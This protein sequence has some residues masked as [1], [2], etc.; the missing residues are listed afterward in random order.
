MRRSLVCVGF[1][2]AVAV[3]VQA[4][5]QR[6]VEIGITAAVLHEAVGYEFTGVRDFEYPSGLRVDFRAIPTR[7]GTVGCAAVFDRFDYVDRSF[8]CTNCSGNIPLAGP[9]EG[10][11]VNNP[12]RVSR[13]GLGA[14]LAT[15]AWHN[16][17]GN[18]GILGGQNRRATREVLPTGTTEARSRAF[19][20]LEAGLMYQWR[21]LLIGGSAEYGVLAKGDGD[22][23]GHFGRANA[24]L[25]YLLPLGRGN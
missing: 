11:Q 18:L 4:Q 14:T 25:A 20:A 5:R 21:D 2:F 22:H 6:S 1:A 19:G 12:W 8:I 24:R 10:Y 9:Y 23:K 3:Q 7:F 16:L 15:Q 13:M 17:R